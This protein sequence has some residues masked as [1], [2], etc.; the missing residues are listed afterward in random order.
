MDTNSNVVAN[1]V[2]QKASTL[3]YMQAARRWMVW[4]EELKN[5]RPVKVPYYVNGEKRGET[6]TPAD[7][8]QLVTYVEAVAVVSSYTGLAFALGRDGAGGCWQGIDLDDV[9]P[10]Q[11][12]DLANVL[13]GYVEFSPSLA[14]CHAI[15]YGLEFRTLG[16]NGTGTEAYAQGRFST[17]TGLMIRDSELTDLAGFVVGPLAERHC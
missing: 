6:D 8:A 7:H 14:G 9:S 12:S 13:P 3:T 1:T 10:N 4:R 15:V 17:Y 11:L 16:S 2:R 5:G